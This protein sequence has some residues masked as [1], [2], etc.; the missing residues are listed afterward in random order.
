MIVL[1]L[2]LVIA[3]IGMAG[4]ALAYL[5]TRD[6]KYLYYAGRIVRFFIV[7]GVVVALVFVAERLVLR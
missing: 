3:L 2:L 7:L 6:K 5:F 4:L 1:R